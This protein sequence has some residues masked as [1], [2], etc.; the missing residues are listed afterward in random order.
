MAKAGGTVNF[1]IGGFHQLIIYDVGTKDGDINT[2]LTTPTTSPNIN[3]PVPLINDPRHRIYRGL[4]PSLQPQDRVEAVHLLDPGTYLVICGV[5]D[6]FEGTPT[7][8]PMFGYIT[9]K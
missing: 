9:V 4:D 2:N 8:D 1:V 3:P 5:K 6:H 7:Q